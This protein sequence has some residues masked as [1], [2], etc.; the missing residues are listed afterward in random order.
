MKHFGKILN[1]VAKGLGILASIKVLQA[2]N[3]DLDQRFNCLTRVGYSDAIKVIM[4]SDLLDHYKSEAISNLKFDETQSYYVAVISIMSS[5][6]LDH[7]KMDSFKKLNS[8]I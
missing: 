6:M 7:Y 2:S 1:Y 3:D 5:D 8:S 4:D